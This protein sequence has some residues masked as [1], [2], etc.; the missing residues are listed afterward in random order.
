MMDLL[1]HR[2]NRFLCVAGVSVLTIKRA[3]KFS[4]LAAASIGC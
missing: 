4:A 1:S 2:N 3:V